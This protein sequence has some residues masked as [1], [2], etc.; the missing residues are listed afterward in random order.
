MFDKNQVIAYMLYIIIVSIFGY[1]AG[2]LK[3][4]KNDKQSFYSKQLE[5]VAQ[6]QEALEAKMG[7]EE[8]NHA[9]EEAIN[10]IYKVEQLG[11]E[12]AWDALTKHS[13]ATELISQATGFSDEEI[14]HIIKSTI[15]MINGNKESK[16]FTLKEI[17]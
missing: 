15:G 13:K 5:F 8:Y 6:Q 2:I 14:F 11:K 7:Q 3:K 9:K 1:G 4:M 16:T 12:L 17:N 10:I